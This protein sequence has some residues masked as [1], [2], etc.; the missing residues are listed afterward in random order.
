M[1]WINCRDTSEPSEI[2][3]ST[4]TDCVRIGGTASGRPAMAAMPTAI[5]APEISPPGS[6]SSKKI[7]PPRPPISSVS[8]TLRVLVRLGTADAIDAGI[9]L[10]P[11]YRKSPQRGQMRQRDA[12]MRGGIQGRGI[13]GRGQAAPSVVITRECG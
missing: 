11:L 2:P 6:L 7:P 10:T 8:S 5:M 4:S 9:R 12:A 3:S 1:C 13:Q